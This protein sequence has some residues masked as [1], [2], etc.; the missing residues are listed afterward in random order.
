MRGPVALDRGP[1]QTPTGD[2]PRRSCSPD[3]PG[4]RCQLR[5]L[6]LYPVDELDMSSPPRRGL[7]VENPLHGR[8]HRPPGLPRR[9]RTHITHAARFEHPAAGSRPPSGE[10]ALPSPNHPYIA[11]VSRPSANAPP[12]SHGNRASVDPRRGGPSLLAS[13]PLSHLDDFDVL[14]APG[15][16]HR[17][18]GRPARGPRPNNPSTS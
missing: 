7:L 8:M 4:Q 18:L 1:R 14:S 16:R 6:L 13:P 5:W 11:P 3:R 12:R 17:V 2:P 9:S 10:P 15:P